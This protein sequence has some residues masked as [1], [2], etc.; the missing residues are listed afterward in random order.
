MAWARWAEMEEDRRRW[1]TKYQKATEPGDPNPVLVRFAHLAPKG[2]ALDLACGL[3]RNAVYL[4]NQGFAVDAVD[5][6]EVALARI[7]HPGI[8]K[9]CADLDH[10]TVSANTYDLIV[11]TMFLD[12]RLYP[13]IKAG[14]KPGGI[15]V[16]QTALEANTH[17]SNPAYKLN[18]GELREVFA[19]LDEVFYEEKD[20]LAALVAR[21][22]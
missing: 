11:D 22:R 18:P 21:K 7:E 1:N 10:Y 4:A 12:R 5:I 20:G 16:F 15:M 6:S 17:V 13:G 2:R 9:I 19:D 8:A 3:G 14:L